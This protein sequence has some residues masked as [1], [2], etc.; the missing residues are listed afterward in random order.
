MA[1]VSVSLGSQEEDERDQ[2][3]GSPDPHHSAERELPDVELM[4]AISPA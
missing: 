1:R 4:R 2:H 3:Q